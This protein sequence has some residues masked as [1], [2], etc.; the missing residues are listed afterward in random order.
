MHIAMYSGDNSNELGKLYFFL[1]CGFKPLYSQANKLPKEEKLTVITPP[2]Q[3]L[4][5]SIA[6]SY[7]VPFKKGRFLDLIYYKQMGKKNPGR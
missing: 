5:T 4:Q 1:L 6:G 2:L 3:P 7:G